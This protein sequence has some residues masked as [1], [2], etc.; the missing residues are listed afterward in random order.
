MNF[1]TLY[2]YIYIYIYL[3]GGGGLRSSTVGE[4][5]TYTMHR[6]EKLGGREQQRNLGGGLCPQTAHGFN[7]LYS[8]F[9]A[10]MQSSGLNESD[11]KT[12]AFNILIVK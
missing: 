6:T 9:C 8:D 7:F 11:C 3:Y 4:I 5:P 1:C 10:S 2:I 12:L